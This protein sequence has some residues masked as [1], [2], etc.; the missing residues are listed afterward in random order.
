MTLDYWWSHRNNR[1]DVRLPD[2]NTPYAEEELP[3]TPESRVATCLTNAYRQLAI[4]RKRT[5]ERRKYRYGLR[6]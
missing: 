5:E 3:G 2:L 1:R 4:A 6:I